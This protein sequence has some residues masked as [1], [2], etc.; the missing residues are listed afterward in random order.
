MET[1]TTSAALAVV[2]ITSLSPKRAVMID[3]L[4]DVILNEGSDAYMSDPVP[5]SG[6]ARRLAR[7]G[8]HATSGTGRSTRRCPPITCTMCRVTYIT[9]V[10]LPPSVS[11]EDWVCGVCLQDL[12]GDPPV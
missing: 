3:Q 2:P 4:T 12:L 10:A 6:P 11:P 9:A 7:R 8:A 1:P 5:T